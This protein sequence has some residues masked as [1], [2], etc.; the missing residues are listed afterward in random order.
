M[1]AVSARNAQGDA[2]TSGAINAYDNTR[3]SGAVNTC[4]A[5]GD[6]C[7]S[8]AASTRDACGDA[9]TSGPVHVCTHVHLPATHVARWPIAHGP[10]VGHSPRVGDPCPRA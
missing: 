7:A 10:I 4:D 5:S 8:G 6:A 1:W 3:T 9:H 2:H